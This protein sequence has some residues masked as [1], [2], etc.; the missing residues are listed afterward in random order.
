MSKILCVGDLH[1]SHTRLPLCINVLKWIASVIVKHKPDAVVYLGDTFDCHAVIR[2][3]CLGIWTSHLRD[4]LDYCTTYWI[5]GNHEFFKP[6]D[7]T[8]NALIPFSAW[9]HKH[10]HVIT[11]PIEIDGLGFVPYLTH[12]ESWKE[13][14]SG[15]E[16]TISFTHNTFLGADLGSR[17]AESGIGEQEVSGDLIVS[18]HIHKRQQLSMGRSSHATSVLYPGTPYSWSA[19]DVDM[20]KGLTMLDT[21][22]LQ[23]KFLES[24]FPTWRKVEV[25]VAASTEISIPDRVRPEDHLLLQLVGS[26]AAIKPILAGGLLDALRSKYASASVSTK[27]LD[28]AKS[29]AGLNTVSTSSLSDTVQSFMSRVYKGTANPEDVKRVVLNALGDET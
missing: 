4:T 8:Y 11:K 9:K 24:P 19:N 12:H 14:T 15:F 21:D 7:S 2:S 1:L 25:D 3:E 6:N 16:S 22:T 20:T 17:I 18:G 23:T 5:A 28:S 29:T 26:R 10:L 13:I 27:F